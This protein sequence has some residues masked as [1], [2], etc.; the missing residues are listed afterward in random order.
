[1]AG[2]VSASGDGVT[3]GQGRG[4]NETVA[5]AMSPDGQHLYVASRGNAVAVFVRNTLTG[6]LAQLGGAAG[7]IADAGDGVTCTNGTALVG[8]RTVTVSSD[9]KSVY[10]GARDGDAVVVLA[11]NPTTGALAQLNGLAVC[12][13]ENGDGVT[14]AVGAGLREAVFVTMSP[15]STN[16]YVASQL[17]DAV[18][19][20]SRNAVTRALTQLCGVAG[21][22]SDDGSDDGMAMVC[23]D[24]NG[25]LGA[26]TVTVSPD[27]LNVYAA[28]YISNAL[29]VFN[30]E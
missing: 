26:L 5:V 9:G 2:C 23:A 6:E 4:L 30:R 16:V 17:S 10:I 13:A 14:C 24:G 3:C 1:V 12:I 25:L 11:R 15:D 19:A 8:L 27:G 7:C 20:F 21:C 22:V 18:A 29:A 28:S